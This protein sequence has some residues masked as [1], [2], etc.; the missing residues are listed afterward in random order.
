LFKFKIYL[1][2][3]Q[4]KSGIWRI[5]GI[6]WEYLIETGTKK[7]NE[8][9]ILAYMELIQALL[10]CPNGEEGNIL[11]ENM[12]LVDMVLVEV[13]GMYASHLRTEGQTG[14]A[15][16]LV[17]TARQISSSLQQRDITNPE[18]LI[19]F[20]KA[21]FQ[22]EK[23]GGQTA[24]F[25][26]LAQGLNL[27]GENL[28]NALIETS[29]QLIAANNPEYQESIVGLV[30]N[31]SNHLTNF[32][33]GN[34]RGKIVSA[35]TV[36][37]YVLS[38]RTD[39]PE[40]TAQTQNN[41]GNAYSDLAPFS[42]NPK[43]EIESAIDCYRAALR[44]Y[45]EIELPQ[46]FATTQNNLGNAYSRLAPFSENPKQEIESAIDCYRAALRVRTSDMRSADCLQT[47]RNLGNLGF[48]EEMW[49]IAIE[50]YK[51][52]IAAVETSRS[53]ASNDER[54]AEIHLQAIGI[55]TNIIQA[56]VNL[57][58][59]DKA[60]EYA[61][62]SRSQRIVD[63]LHSNDLYPKGD[64]PEIVTQ[65]LAQ[66]HAKQKAID[67]LRKQLSDGT[68]RQIETV[69]DST[70]RHRAIAQAL[71]PEIAQLE[72]DKQEIWKQLRRHDP[73][74]AG[75]VKVDTLP[76]AQMQALIAEQPHTAILYFYSTTTATLVFIVQANSIA[77][78][79]C[80]DFG[81]DAINT[82]LF[83][84]WQQPYI[85]VKPIWCEQMPTVLAQLAQHLQLNQLLKDHIPEHIQELIIV[86]HFYLHQIP[87]AALPINLSNSPRLSGEGLGE[88]SPFLS[89]RYK[90][91]TISSL[92]ILQYCQNRE[93]IA[94]QN[95]ATVENA[96]NDLPFAGYEGEQVAKIFDVPRDR[97]LQR[98]TEA[99]KDNYRHLLANSNSILSSHHAASRIDTPLESMLKLGDGFIALNELLMSR[100]PNLSEIFLSCCETGLGAPQNLTDDILTLATGFLCAGA[101]SVISSLWTVDDLATALFSTYYH[102]AR[103]SGCDR[104]TAIANAQKQLREFNGAELANGKPL[105]VALNKYLEQQK[106]ALGSTKEE[107]A[108]ISKLL[109][110]TL[111]SFKDSPSPF[112]SPFFWAG[113]VCHGLA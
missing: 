83:E 14:A 8:E 77:L 111:E 60:I 11:D 38:L 46:A 108:K 104:P 50:G 20:C 54:R 72:A 4:K 78:H 98:Q 94:T 34:P 106:S 113:F 10:S 15:D 13:M 80:P 75:Q 97:R 51:P 79:K 52:A 85:T 92:Q 26:G 7:M 45:K 43:Q 110:E 102:N 84:N 37:E 65:L 17:D 55:Y 89:D 2:I 87:F 48:K 25:A 74:I 86:P 95:Y 16:F 99:T 56:F 76:F 70:S 68:N 41:L 44:V 81:R 105:R 88:R 29:Q 58:Q 64:I 42:E 49:E 31:I 66:F 90:L 22:A 59:Y 32:P 33:L 73:V 107:R 101:R 23:D 36:Y 96:T 109:K 67:I 24:V 61:E 62:R 40:K 69:S 18:G 112:A 19:D 91:R 9:R 82:F 35:I 27:V 100:Y 12:S 30:E 71:T 28:G 57:E 63:L 6:T 53:W 93:A 47:G 39:N 5:D 3:A 1:Q 21:L 103:Y